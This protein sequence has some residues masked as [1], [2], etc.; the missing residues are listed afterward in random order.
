MREDGWRDGQCLSNCLL[1]TNKTML[2]V[3]G[4]SLGDF[5]GAPFAE[6]TLF[7]FLGIQLWVPFVLSN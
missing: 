5:I 6:N 4:S 1:S 7:L 3:V 2:V